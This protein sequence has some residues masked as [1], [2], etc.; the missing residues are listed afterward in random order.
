MDIEEIQRDVRFRAMCCGKGREEHGGSSCVAVREQVR[1][2]RRNVLFLLTSSSTF[3]GQK[4]V[5]A[6]D[7]GAGREV[8]V[9][10]R[11]GAKRLRGFYW[12]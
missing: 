12:Y 11:C 10:R 5:A 9:V 6:R 1:P 4:R 8:R 7:S 3:S 2:S